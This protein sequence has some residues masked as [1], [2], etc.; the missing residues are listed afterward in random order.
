[1]I[2]FGL[3]KNLLFKSV[4]GHCEIWPPMAGYFI[5]FSLGTLF[6]D[7]TELCIRYF[8]RHAYLNYDRWIYFCDTW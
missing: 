7:A 4:L 5:S 1:M 3:G 6:I 2:V 8:I